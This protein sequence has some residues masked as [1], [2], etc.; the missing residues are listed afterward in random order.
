MIQINKNQFLH[1]IGWFLG[2]NDGIIRK[3]EALQLK[4]PTEF[5]NFI[6]SDSLF[7][8]K[9]H[10][11][12]EFTQFNKGITWAYYKLYK[13]F[14]RVITPANLSEVFNEFKTN[15][16]NHKYY[17]LKKFYELEINSKTETDRKQFLNYKFKSIQEIRKKKP[18]FMGL[19]TSFFIFSNDILFLTQLDDL[20]DILAKFRCLRF[21]SGFFPKFWIGFIELLLKMK[22]FHIYYGDDLVDYNERI[23]KIEQKLIKKA[24]AFRLDNKIFSINEIFKSR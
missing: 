14:D 23:D 2:L 17:F 10:V 13:A 12:P 5:I 9:Y 21:K 22:A 4:D 16:S 19:V 11:E 3:K 15:I 8:I 1:K 20:N 24:R 7:S 18:Y 6:H